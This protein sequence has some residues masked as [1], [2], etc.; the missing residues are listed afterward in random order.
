M[1]LVHPEWQSQIVFQENR[2][3]VLCI[4][5]AGYFSRTIQELLYQRETGKGKFVLSDGADVCE[6]G[7]TTELILSPFQ[8]NFDDKRFQTNIVKRLV[9]IA[10]EDE[11]LES[12]EIRNSILQYFYQLTGRLE[13]DVEVGSEFDIQQLVKLANVRPAFSD[14]SLEASVVDYFSLLRD[15]LGIKLILCVNLRNYFAAERLKSFYET[16]LLKKINLLLLENFAKNDKI[17]CEDWLI[18]DEDL[19]EI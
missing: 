5:N 7:K 8:L 19:C 1:K 16:I 13:Y 2:V 12:Q 10:N 11:Y 3:Q 14:E 6:L 4:E 15:V 9:Q 17:D 18:V